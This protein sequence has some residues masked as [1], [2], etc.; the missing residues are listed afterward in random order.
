MLG[1]TAAGDGWD[2]VHFRFLQEAAKGH[3]SPLTYTAPRPGKAA[4]EGCPNWHSGFVH[5]ALNLQGISS[6]FEFGG[7][8]EPWSPD[9]L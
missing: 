9:D 8:W 2:P 1:L 4:G 5:P 7:V 3:L 6:G